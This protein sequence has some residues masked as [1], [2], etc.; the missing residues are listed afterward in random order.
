MESL[1]S[2]DEVLL[3]EIFLGI[4]LIF[5][6]QLPLILSF[7]LTVERQIYRLQKFWKFF[8]LL[9]FFLS[10]ILTPTIDGYTQL[11]FSF[12]TIFFYFLL[13]NLL[14][15]RLSAKFPSL[16]SVIF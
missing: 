4:L 14:E 1:W 10:G 13:F 12:S 2:F 8:S 6:S 16:L 9:T 5:F 11:G 3:I 7:S 15:K